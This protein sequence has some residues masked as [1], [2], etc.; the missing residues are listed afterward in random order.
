MSEEPVE[1]VETEEE[2]DYFAKCQE[3]INDDSFLEKMR[4]P[5]EIKNRI[6]TL[7][8]QSP[9]I[10]AEFKKN[11]ILYNKNPEYSEYQ[12]MF[13]NIK[14]NLEKIG[15]QF[16]E[17]LNTIQVDTEELNKKLNCL[18]A[19]IVEERQKNNRLKRRLGIVDNE[20]NA[21]SEMIYDFNKMYEEGYLR[22]WGLVISILAVFLIIKNMSSNTTGDLQSNLKNMSE[23]AKT[24]GTDIYNKGVSRVK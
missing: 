10:L 5:E 16:F 18:N 17:L 22:N 12:Q 11:F 8:E 1:P 20:N 9:Y 2:T 19:L 14:S 4:N 23:Q 24:V 21:S 13:Q 6:K 7:E 3:F 15:A